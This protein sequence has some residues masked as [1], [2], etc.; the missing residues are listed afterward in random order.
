MNTIITGASSNHFAILQKLLRSIRQYHRPDEVEMVV[1]D[2][3]LTE[4]ERASLEMEFQSPVRIFDYS[5]YPSYYD[6]KVAAGEYAWKPA[7]IKE[8]RQALGERTYIW[9]DAG[10]RIMSPLDKL[11]LFLDTK[12]FFS[13]ATHGT[14]QTWTSPK[15]FESLDPR[16]QAYIPHKMRNGAIIG[17]NE[18]FK[19]VQELM[20]TYAEWANTKAIIAPEGSNRDNHRQDQSCLTLLYWDYARTNPFHT[21]IPC[22]SIMVHSDHIKN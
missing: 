1:W 2:L 10:D 21:D 9:L 16:F 18:R 13:N 7:L 14:V 3:G 11:F 15:V 19:W 5:K 12:G 4:Q 17:F 22:A 20:D 8:T 6:I